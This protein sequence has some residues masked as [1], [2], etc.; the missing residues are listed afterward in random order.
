M[1]GQRVSSKTNAEGRRS[2]ENSR[3]RLPRTKR[4]D[5]WE[6]MPMIVSPLYNLLHFWESWSLSR[7]CL[8]MA[9]ANRYRSV[10]SSSAMTLMM[11]AA[12]DSM[13]G[14]WRWDRFCCS[15]GRGRRA[16]HDG[17]LAGSS[18]RVKPQYVNYTKKAKRVDVRKLKENI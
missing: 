15:W 11:A 5:D 9:T 14:W 6:G 3:P 17:H 10:P 13:M 18:R 4:R 12:P 1:Q 8:K 2:M 7:S 16:R